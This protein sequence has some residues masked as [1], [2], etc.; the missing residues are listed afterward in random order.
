ME[1]LYGN[2]RYKNDPKIL[3][4]RKILKQPNGCWLWNGA[5]N[6]DGYGV[7][8]IKA[9]GAHRASYKMYKGEIPKGILVCH[10]CDI[11]RCVNPDHLFLGTQL[12]NIRDAQSKNRIKTA[13]CNTYSKYV[14]GCR[15]DGCVLA[16]KDYMQK[17]TSKNGYNKKSEYY[18]KN[19]DV[20][21]ERAKQYAIDNK[22]KVKKKQ[23]DWYEANKQRV[24]DRVAK[25]R[26]ELKNDK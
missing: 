5:L 6:K 16:Y 9:E 2:Q 21:K 26:N 7:F 10:K 17:Y 12:D 23:K 20:V 13:V 8:G 19:K 14:K 25:R 22:E 3:F 15:C 1:K 24:I 11:P 18:Q 4:E